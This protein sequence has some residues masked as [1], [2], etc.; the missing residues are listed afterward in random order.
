MADMAEAGQQIAQIGVDVDG[1][2]VAAFDH[3]VADRDVGQLEHILQDGAFALGEVGHFGAALLVEGN[4]QIV[5][6][7]YRAAGQHGLETVPE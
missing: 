5:T 7:R 4:L 6:Q 3:D 1:L 2:D